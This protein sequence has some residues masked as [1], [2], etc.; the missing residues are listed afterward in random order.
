MHVNLWPSFH[1]QVYIH[2]FFFFVSDFFSKF[3]QGTY[4]IQDLDIRVRLS[5]DIFIFY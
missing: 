2:F 4:Q 3:E 5:Y 1:L